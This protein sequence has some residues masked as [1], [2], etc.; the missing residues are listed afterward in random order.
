MFLIAYLLSI[1]FLLKSCIFSRSLCTL[2]S[3]VEKYVFKEL[4]LKSDYTFTCLVIVD[5]FPDI[6]D[7]EPK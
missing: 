6:L 4:L 5:S 3:L 7:L 2:I 1:E